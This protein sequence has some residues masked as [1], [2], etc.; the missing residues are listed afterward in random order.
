VDGVVP[1]RD[2]LDAR[3]REDILFLA[4]ECAGLLFIKQLADLGDRPT[5]GEPDATED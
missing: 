5:V 4:G 1:G 3:A 2:P